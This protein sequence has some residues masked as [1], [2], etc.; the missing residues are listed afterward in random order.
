MGHDM[1]GYIQNNVHIGSYL[2]NGS[3]NRASEYSAYIVRMKLVPSNGHINCDTFP[4]Q[5]ISYITAWK[6]V[7]MY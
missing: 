3:G 2:V 5:Y 6:F 7:V 4:S 1:C